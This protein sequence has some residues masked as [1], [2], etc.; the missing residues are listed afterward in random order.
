MPPAL[1]C[2]VL[3][4]AVL[5]AAEHEYP[6]KKRGD[7]TARL[8]LE[9]QGARGELGEDRVEVRLSGQA[10]LTLD[11]EGPDGLEVEEEIE[12]MK[13]GTWEK[14]RVSAWGVEEGRV[15]WRVRRSS[16]ARR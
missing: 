10:V 13:P 11:V 7:V 5:P 14:R 16:I 4:V 6:V 3:A 8:R 15:R 9:V 2:L 1:A 12:G